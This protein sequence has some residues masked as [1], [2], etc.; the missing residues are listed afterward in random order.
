[1]NRFSWGVGVGGMHGFK[2][3]GMGSR[4]EL[5]RECVLIFVACCLVYFLNERA[6]TSGDSVPN[7]LLA[8][9]WLI[10]GTFHFD[11]F[12]DGYLYKQFH[13]QPY[14]FMENQAGHLTT[15]YPIGTAIITFPI[16]ICFYFYSLISNG[17]QAIDITQADFEIQRVMFEK[18]A[19][20]IVAA[21][22]VVIFYLITRLK[23]SKITSIISTFIYAFA[24]STWTVSSQGLWQ[25]GSINLVLLSILLCLFKFNRSPNNKLLLAGGILTGLL[26]VIRPSNLLFVVGM[27]IYVSITHRKKAIFLLVGMSS[28]LLGIAWNLSYFGTLMGGYGALY[29]LFSFTWKQFSNASLG[30]LFSP[31][32][33]LF[34][35]SPILLYGIFGFLQ[36]YKRKFRKDEQLILCLLPTCLLLYLQYSFFDVWWAGFSYGPRFFTDFLP[37]FCLLVAYAIEH[38]SLKLYKVAIFLLVL[39]YSVFVQIVGVFGM[40]EWNAVPVTVDTPKYAEFA[41]MRLWQ[42]R[43]SQIERQAHSLFF[44]I[45]RPAEKP[46]YAQELEG[47]VLAVHDIN[48]TP[49]RSA[50]VAKPGD[51]ILLNAKVKNTG[52]TQWLGYETGLAKGTVRVRVRFVEGTTT[53]SDQRLFVPNR[54]MPQE[55]TTALGLVSFPT[56]VGTY[57]MVFDLVA[58]GI[59]EINPPDG[60][61]ALYSLEAKVQD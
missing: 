27:V 39:I 40:P 46:A 57:R 49:V 14:F 52:T 35:F 58:E 20:L 2:Y 7:T 54:A 17:F 61:F 18:T 43:D 6:I 53:I 56:Q 3:L 42:I 48:K 31:S 21:L 36:V 32:R 25:H 5:R 1:M 60:R 9:N 10:N 13:N 12:R 33:G 38:C 4:R 11:A 22:S 26:P 45:T 47:I 19:A 59:R 8:F 41:N 29:N 30:L 28:A 16:Y 15:S 24:T 44:Q 34:T 50:I 51:S 23:F 55:T 37:L